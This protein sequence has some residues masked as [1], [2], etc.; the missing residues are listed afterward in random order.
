MVQ[1]GGEG[2]RGLGGQDEREEQVEEA[3]KVG[4]PPSV[5]RLITLTRA[6][7]HTLHSAL[8]ASWNWE[9]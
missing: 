5:S 4:D 7:A 1:G 8:T 2:R 6:R 9:V 3:Q